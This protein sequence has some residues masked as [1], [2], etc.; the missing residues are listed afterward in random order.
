MDIRISCIGA[1]D[2]RKISQITELSDVHRAFSSNTGRHSAMEKSIACCNHTLKIEVLYA[3][4]EK[5]I[6]DQQVG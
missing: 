4:G 6:R 3:P 5:T 2:T 1:A